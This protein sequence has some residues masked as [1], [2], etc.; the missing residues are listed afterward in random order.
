MTDIVSDEQV[1]VLHA[2]NKRESIQKTYTTGAA[3]TAKRNSSKKDTVT[4]GDK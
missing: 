4:R 3:P 2:W 1:H